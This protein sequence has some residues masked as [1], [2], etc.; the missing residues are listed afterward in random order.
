M[1]V[2][3]EIIAPLIALLAGILILVVTLRARKRID[4]YGG[5]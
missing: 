4:T 2:D 1:N 3:R 5:M